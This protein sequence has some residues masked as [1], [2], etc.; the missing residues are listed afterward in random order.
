MSLIEIDYDECECAVPLSVRLLTWQAS[1]RGA[2]QPVWWPHR[3]RRAAA[4]AAGRRTRVPSPPAAQHGACANGAGGTGPAGMGARGSKRAPREDAEERSGRGG[5]TH[6]EP[7][8]PPNEVDQSASLGVDVARDAEGAGAAAEQS[9]DGAR[10]D[11]HEVAA[12]T[13]TESSDTEWSDES[14][15][16]PTRGYMRRRTAYG[17]YEAGVAAGAQLPGDIAAAAADAVMEGA[18]AAVAGGAQLVIGREANARVFG[19]TAAMGADTVKKA[20]WQR[21]LYYEC[22]TNN[23]AAFRVACCPCRTGVFLAQLLSTIVNPIRI[24]VRKLLWPEQYG[25]RLAAKMGLRAGKQSGIPPKEVVLFLCVAA[26]LAYFLAETGFEEGLKE[27]VQEDDAILQA[28]TGEGMTVPPASAVSNV[29]PG[30]ESGAAHGA[31]ATSPTEDEKTQATLSVARMGG[32]DGATL[33]GG[34]SP[35][36]GG[37]S[38]PV[39]ESNV[40]GLPPSARTGVA[41]GG[42]MTQPA[43]RKDERADVLREC[44]FNDVATRLLPQINNAALAEEIHFIHTVE[45]LRSEIDTNAAIVI[46]GAMRRVLVSFR[47]TASLANV[48][49][50]LNI[51]KVG[52]DN[53]HGTSGPHIHEGFHTAYYRGGVAFELETRLA[54]LFRERAADFNHELWITGHS[55][56][57]A[58]ATIL[59]W[60]LARHAILPDSVHIY[61]VTFGAPR[62]G[63]PGFADA[64]D[65]LDNVTLWR[66]VNRHDVVPRV[67]FVNYEHAGILIHLKPNGGIQLSQD[68]F[69]A[70]C[71]TNCMCGN[72]SVRD[73]LLGVYQE[74]Q[75]ARD[76]KWADAA[77]MCTPCMGSHVEPVGEVESDSETAKTGVSD[78]RAPGKSAS[79]RPRGGDGV[80]TR[81]KSGS[82]IAKMVG[83]MESTDANSADGGAAA[84]EMPST[85]SAHTPLV[86]TSTEFDPSCF[87]GYLY[88][89]WEV[90]DWPQASSPWPFYRTASD[91]LTPPPD[92]D[93]PRLIIEE[94]REGPLSAPASSPPASPLRSTRTRTRVTRVTTVDSESSGVV[95]EDQTT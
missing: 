83:Q 70:G 46:N 87:A 23:F 80:V 36:V 14:T 19:R 62:V 35:E 15:S 5:D 8:A 67:P 24:G 64:F 72:M 7:S 66:V 17:H 86:V 79:R 33:A 49:T 68:G 38:E 58:L 34:Q 63:S 94:E 50:D 52:A 65:A 21:E 47:G 42:G 45:E 92:Y 1:R 84:V 51:L 13:S 85:T 32:T 69:D 54:E 90:E 93:G 41:G 26:R 37:G 95:A 22:R 30:R 4:A 40:V 89:I 29:V 75:P 56:G 16:T 25:G 55:L 9:E 73:H 82:E 60:R 11:I 57:G 74:R 81:A 6:G 18:A 76:I 88:S 77:Q 78:G 48:Y 71:H 28:A 43:M 91:W 10:V 31:A 61:V 44:I 53:R 39:S 3:P 20:P 59:A 2:A 12:S 27:A